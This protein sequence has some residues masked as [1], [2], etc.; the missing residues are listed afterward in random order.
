MNLTVTVGLALSLLA[1]SAFT[2]SPARAFDKELASKVIFDVENLMRGVASVGEMEMKV[3]NPKWERTMRMK[4]WETVPDKMLVTVTFPAQDA[5]VGTLKLGDDLWS[6][7]PHIDQV[8]KIPPSLMLDSW[9]GSDFTN[10]DITRDSSIND[11]Y[12]VENLESGE[13]EGQKSWRITLRPKPGSAVVWEKVVV[14]ASQDGHRP[15]RQEYYNEKDQLVR[16]MTLS[17]YRPANNGKP[18]PFKWR[19]ESRLEGERY[20]EVTVLSMEFRDKLPDK[21]FSI[22][23]LKKGRP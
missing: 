2:P 1:A 10:D 6:Y 8:Q 14:E 15:L 11:D 3:H 20:T 22:R 16:V 7:N 19:I 13:M 5:G 4:F 17:D 23:S 12:D 18:Y 21:V 9:M